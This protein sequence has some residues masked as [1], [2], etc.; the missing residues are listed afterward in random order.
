VHSQT[1]EQMTTSQNISRAEAEQ[2][3]LAS[4]Q[5][6][7]RFIEADDVAGMILFL[8]GPDSRDITGAALPIDG[9]WSI[10]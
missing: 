10:N 6:G 4:K 3:F 8:C 7:G 5:P 2:R 1:I 9:G